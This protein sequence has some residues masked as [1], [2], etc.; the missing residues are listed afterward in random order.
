[1]RAVVMSFYVKEIT[2]I[3]VKQSIYSSLIR[4]PYGKKMLKFMK[5]FNVRDD[6]QLKSARVLYF[7]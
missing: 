5:S 1:M 3:N 7:T 6:M 4:E 2:I